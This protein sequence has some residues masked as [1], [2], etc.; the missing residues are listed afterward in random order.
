MKNPFRCGNPYMGFLTCVFAVLCLSATAGTLPDA[1][2]RVKCLEAN[3]T[4]YLD[5][6]VIAGPSTRLVMRFSY[7]TAE[8]GGGGIGYGTGS[9]GLINNI[10]T[11][12]YEEGQVCV[13]VHVMADGSVSEAHV[14][15][16]KK[17]QTTIT[18]RMVQNQCVNEAKRARYKSGKEELRVI[19]FK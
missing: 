13:E 14:I 3:G 2:R 8:E 7:T 10:N 18:N 15:N 19:I 11:T 17:Y 4:Q 12:V 6:G 1:Y 5:T 16:N 9:R